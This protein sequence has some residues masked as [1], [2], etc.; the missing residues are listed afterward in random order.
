LDVRVASPEARV[1]AQRALR[2]FDSVLQKIWTAWPSW[3]DQARATITKTALPVLE[4]RNRLVAALWP[5]QLRAS[6]SIKVAQ[7]RWRSGQTELA[8]HGLGPIVLSPTTTPDEV[9]LKMA[10]LAARHGTL[11]AEELDPILYALERYLKINRQRA[12]EVFS[13][14]TMGWTG[15]LS[16]DSF[17]SYLRAIAWSLRTP[18]PR[19]PRDEIRNDGDRETLRWVGGRRRPEGGAH[20][21]RQRR[22]YVRL[23]SEEPELHPWALGQPALLSRLAV[24]YEIE[25]H[26]VRS[27]WRAGKITALGCRRREERTVC[28]SPVNGTIEV[29]ASERR[30]WENQCAKYLD[31]RVRRQLSRGPAPTPKKR[32]YRAAVRRGGSREQAA[33]V[34][35]AR[36]RDAGLPDLRDES[37]SATPNDQ[38]FS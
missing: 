11:D 32:L 36:A 17:R 20:A 30:V 21:Q 13:R 25:A 23:P 8:S 38:R 2:R 12:R 5:H 19:A 24:D 37:S 27:W 3:D 29:P 28:G 22:E 26:V 33:A 4:G 7:W 35:R 31:K 9:N 10:F 14:A 16:P 15:D 34:I 6:P 18:S 1:G